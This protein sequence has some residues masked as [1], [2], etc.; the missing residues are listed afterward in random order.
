MAIAR[1][2]VPPRPVRGLSDRRAARRG[3]DRPSGA[4]SESERAPI[5]TEIRGAGRNLSKIVLPD[6]TP[7]SCPSLEGGGA[8][9]YVDRADVSCRLFRSEPYGERFQSTCGS[10]SF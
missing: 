5:G 10:S 7:R 1:A 2:A 6:Q 4:R 9:A 3:N 8:T